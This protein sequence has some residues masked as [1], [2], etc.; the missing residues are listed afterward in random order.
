MSP[1][2]DFV[3]RK[4][5]ISGVPFH[6]INKA[7]TFSGAQPTETFLEAFRRSQTPSNEASHTDA[8]KADGCGKMVK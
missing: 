7:W 8:D 1:L 4:L 3:R 2:A 6:V 5:G